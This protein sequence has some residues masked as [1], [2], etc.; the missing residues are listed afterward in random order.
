MSKKGSAMPLETIAVTILI[1]L[2]LVVL[3]IAFREQI[4]QL[5]S[6]FGNLLKGTTESVNTINI[7]Q[8]Q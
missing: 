5:F 2:V 3:A 4:S 8:L 6:S 7:E 1:L